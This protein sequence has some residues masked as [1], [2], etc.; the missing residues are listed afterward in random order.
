MLTR[1]IQHLLTKGKKT[2]QV[3]TQIS[4]KKATNKGGVEYSQAQF[5]AVRELTQEEHTDISKLTE[6]FMRYTQHV[7]LDFDNAVYTDENGIQPLKVDPQTG[8][9]LE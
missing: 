7:S 5:K 1:Y 6:Q 4:L 3:V 8:E 9:I 2:N